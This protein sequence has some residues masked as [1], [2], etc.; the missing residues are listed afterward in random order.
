MFLVATDNIATT[1]KIV[2]QNKMEKIE[3]IVKK[4]ENGDNKIIANESYS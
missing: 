4:R 3:K 2:T 1:E